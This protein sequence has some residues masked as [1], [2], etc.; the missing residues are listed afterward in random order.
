MWQL[1]TSTTTL[2]LRQGTWTHL[3]LYKAIVRANDE[4]YNHYGSYKRVAEAEAATE[5]AV[6]E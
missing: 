1:C 5:A 4:Q 2:G 6:E 3:D